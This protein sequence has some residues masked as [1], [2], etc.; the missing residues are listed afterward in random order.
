M[1]RWLRMPLSR[2][3]V[4]L[5]GA[6]TGIIV[7]TIVVF[8]AMRL[9]ENRI[10]KR[11]Q[12]QIRALEAQRVAGLQPP[13]VPMRASLRPSDLA[14]KL[15]QFDGAQ[16]SLRDFAGRVVFLNFWATYCA[17]C[18]AELPTIEDLARRM[19]RDRFAFILV[20]TEREDTVRRFLA[21]HSY[22]LPFYFS[23]ERPPA[24]LLPAVLPTTFVIGP[25]GSVLLR[26]DGAARWNDPTFLNYLRSL[27]VPQGRG[28][29]MKGRSESLFN[30]R[31]EYVTEMQ[32]HVHG[33]SSRSTSYPGPSPG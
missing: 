7:F 21:R 15:G 28:L 26:Q 5:V 31:D 24:V 3:G 19:P 27:E 29:L 10:L 12:A 8:I 2:L 16:S 6:T 20:S 25:T 9:A 23:V 11:G 1:D 17:P 13:F 14:W 22:S 30:R 33:R 32:V 4:F 18:I